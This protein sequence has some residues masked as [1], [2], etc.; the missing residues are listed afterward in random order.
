MTEL[1]VGDTENT[2]DFDNAEDPADPLNW[3]SLYKWF[4]VLLISL[5]S[6]VV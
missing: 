1:D 5:M 3:S 2:V 4:L 6:L